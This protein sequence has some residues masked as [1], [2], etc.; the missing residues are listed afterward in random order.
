[1]EQYNW[2]HIAD[3]GSWHLF[4]GTSTTGDVYCITQQG[5]Q[6]ATGIYFTIDA[7][8]KSRAIRR[9]YEGGADPIWKD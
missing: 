3:Y 5:V 9:P 6:Q 2:Q 7:A 1:M 4:A 8:L